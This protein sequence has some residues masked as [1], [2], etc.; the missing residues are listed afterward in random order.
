MIE[1]TEFINVTET[2][3]FYP[4]AMYPPANEIPRLAKYKRGRIIY[5]GRH[6]EIYDRASALLQDTPHADQLKTLFIAVNVMDVLCTKPADLLVGDRPTFDAGTGAGS[7]QQTRLDSIVEE[8]DLTQMIYE[9]AIGGAYRGDSF[10]KTYYGQRADLSEI[11][12]AGLTPPKVPLEPIIEPVDPS[13]VFPELSR[14]SKKAFKAIN[15]AWIE[16]E[17]SRTSRI[18][19]VVPGVMQAEKSYLNVERHLPGYVIY[20]RYRVDDAG[21]DT[22]WGAPISTY[23][24]G[25]RV[26]TGR[27][28]DV[29]E[30]GLPVMLVDHAPHKATDDDWRGES[31]VEKLESVLSA[32][33]DRLVQIDYILWKHSDP[34]AYGPEFDEADTVRFGGRYIPLDKTDAT[35]GYMT[36]DSQLEGAF[37]E[38]DVLLGL[39]YQVAETPQWLFGTTLAADKGGTGTSH[40]D[41][42]AIKARFMPI[43]SKVKRIRAHVDR[44]IRN[45]LWKAQLLENA[46]NVGVDGF[47]AYEPAYPV[48]NWRDGIPQDPKEAAEVAQIRTGNKPTQS[49]KDAIRELDGISDAE[50]EA[51]LAR[52]EADEQRANGTVESS[53]FNGDAA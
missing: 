21:V 41:A 17:I 48:I 7:T 13:I 25:E 26:P 42:G 15:I 5:R 14:G 23:Y 53:I 36:W 10:I 2:K 20:E 49:V 47:T 16:H 37:K 39:V 43:L 1:L 22:R 8:N 35:P 29:V 34:T 24:I 6:A 4:G 50:A 51:V 3:L 9:Q 11:E 38:L 32:I 40:T 18:F 45:A 33:N 44:A 52:I 27:E 31:T 19:P 28:V 46:A 30:T 12:Q